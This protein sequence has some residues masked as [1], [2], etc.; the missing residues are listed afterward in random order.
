M[1]ELQALHAGALQEPEGKSATPE[2]VEARMV[3]SEVVE[4]PLHG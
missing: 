3:K 2:V 1:D 4:A